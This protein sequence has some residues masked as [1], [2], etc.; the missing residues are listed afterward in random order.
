MKLSDLE[1]SSEGTC[2]AML[3]SA[4]GETY[5]TQRLADKLSCGSKEKKTLTLE[6]IMKK[7]S[8]VTLVQSMDGRYQMEFREETL[9]VT[10]A[11]GNPKPLQL[12]AEY[13]PLE[14]IYFSDV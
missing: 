12:K 8:S 3:D 7:G 13:E 6:G 5:M 10:T 14:E 2:C 9:P 11:I 4:S 1:S